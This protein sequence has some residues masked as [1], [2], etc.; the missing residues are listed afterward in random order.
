MK[1][2][3]PLL[4]GAIVALSTFAC[5]KDML[6]INFAFPE[7][8][9]TLNSDSTITDTI[10]EITRSK[11]INIDSLAKSKNT[12]VDKLKS[13]KPTKFK[14]ELLSNSKETN[15]DNF[16]SGTVSISETGLAKTLVGTFSTS[17]IN[18]GATT[19]EMLATGV[20]VLPYIKSGNFTVSCKIISK[21]NPTKPFS[22]KITMVADGVANPTN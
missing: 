11:V 12:S 19:F 18:P 6:D 10:V 17:N 20:D 7:T 14:F 16:K 9:I 1:T 5:K 2:L 4:I 21:G 15:F 8:P 22:I 13:I 3:K